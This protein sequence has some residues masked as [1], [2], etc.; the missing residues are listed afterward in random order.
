LGNESNLSG[1]NIEVYRVSSLADALAIFTGNN[2]SVPHGN[3][4]APDSYLSTME[5]VAKRLCDRAIVLRGSVAAND[6]ELNESRSALLKSADAFDSRDYYSAASQCFVAGLSLRRLDL[7]NNSQLQLERKFNLIAKALNDLSV[8][9]QKRSLRTLGDL[10][11][12]AIVRDRLIEAKDIL[13]EQ[14]ASN[15][16]SD[17]IAYAIERHNSAIVWS[18]FFGLEG[19]LFSLEEQ[20][21]REACLKR[22][23]EAEER[24]SYLELYLGGL[25]LNRK[26][27]DQAYSHLQADEPALCVFEAS[28]AKAEFNTILS[29]LF[30]GK[31]D[32]GLLVDQKLHQA[33]EVLLRQQSRGLFPI[34]GYSYYE[35]AKFLAKDDPVLAL[36]F[37]EYSLELSNLDAYFPREKAVDKAKFHLDTQYVIGFIAGLVAGLLVMIPFAL[38]AK[39]SKKNRRR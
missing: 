7:R 32:V 33:E 37:A 1:L 28:K 13:R 36:Q 24:A 3:L 30:I 34:M 31:D 23:E 20:H 6:S 10:E 11:T 9:T 21:V 27:L 22:L 35:Y 4:T 8:S 39:K 16:S 38:R 15:L 2:Y 12:E 25:E 14:N 17:A 5:G 26:T 18:R 19:E 29:S